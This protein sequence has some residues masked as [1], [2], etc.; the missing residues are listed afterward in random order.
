MEPTFHSRGSRETLA[1]CNSTRSVPPYFGRLAPRTACVR[2][3][4]ARRALTA[5]SERNPIDLIVPRMQ[6]ARDQKRAGRILFP[7]HGQDRAR[8]F[9]KNRAAA[10]A[11]GAIRN[12]LKHFWRGPL[13]PAGNDFPTSGIAGWSKHDEASPCRLRRA[14][15]HFSGRSPT[16]TANLAGKK[17]VNIASLGT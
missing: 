13:E 12:N 3:N 7:I 1:A 8:K 5:A 11:R 4:A 6:I 2:S 17:N 9:T 10:F 15:L 16:K 14:A